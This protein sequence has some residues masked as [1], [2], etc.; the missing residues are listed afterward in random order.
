ML[1][2]KVWHPESV[3]PLCERLKDEK[4]DPMVRRSAAFASSAV[5]GSRLSRMPVAN[6]NAM[7][8]TSTARSGMEITANQLRR[9]LLGGGEVTSG[10][11][12]VSFR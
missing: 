10:A 5:G 8:S 7:S 4:E 3:G 1:A 11:F 6:G 12:G 9:K 2:A